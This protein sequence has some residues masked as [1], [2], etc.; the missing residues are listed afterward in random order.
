MTK[1]KSKAVN[2]RRTDNAMAKIAKRKG[3]RRH[4][5]IKGVWVLIK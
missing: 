2:G 4:I 3:Q 5:N 1:R